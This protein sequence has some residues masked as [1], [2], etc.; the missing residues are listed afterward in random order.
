MGGVER[1]AFIGY[2][3]RRRR[4]PLTGELRW[5]EPYARSG[6]YLACRIGH[7]T[8]SVLCA[9]TFHG[10]AVRGRWA[11][12]QVHRHDHGD[13]NECVVEKVKLHSRDNQL[14]NA[15]GDVAS[16]EVGAGRGLP[17]QQ[18]V[19]E[20]VPHL[21]GEGGVP[22]SPRLADKART[23]QEEPDKHDDRIRVVK[24]LRCD[25]PRK[26]QTE[27]APGFRALPPENKHLHGLGDV[28]N[29]V[30]HDDGE[31]APQGNTVIAGIEQPYR[32]GDPADETRTFDS[33]KTQFFPSSAP[34]GE[35]RR[36]LPRDPLP[37]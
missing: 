37:L 14:R 36:L 28:L 18:K 33:R 9:G 12:V 11:H 27:K 34:S 15:C 25:E 16:E 13:E 23:Q 10:V 20:M 24:E 35:A 6:G 29:P 19:L 4:R 17:N 32:R 3:R 1:Q 8:R 31:E 2:A 21:N 22:P 26:R 5:E 30:G 7:V